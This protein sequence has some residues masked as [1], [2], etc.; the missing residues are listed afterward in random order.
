MNKS[1]KIAEAKAHFCELVARAE[2]GEEIL[3]S[4]GNKPVARIVPLG[5]AAAR[6]PGIAGH[7]KA[8]PAWADLADA[9]AEPVDEEEQAAAEGDLS[10]EF[11]ITLTSGPA[12]ASGRGS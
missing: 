11:G 12:P 7:W 4:R 5:G 9:V 3:I 2:A 8:D 6:R 1:V 10:D